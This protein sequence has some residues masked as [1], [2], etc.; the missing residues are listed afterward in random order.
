MDIQFEYLAD[1]PAPDRRAFMQA[2]REDAELRARYAEW[3]AVCEAVRSRQLQAIPARDLLVFAALE[4]AGM[5][6]LLSP[7]ERQRLRTEWPVLQDSLDAPSFLE[8]VVGRI[9]E[10][11]DDF[12]ASWA[13]RE[14]HL[15]SLDAGVPR[16]RPGRFVSV[17][18]RTS[19]VAAMIV[20]VGILLFVA[21]RDA[22]WVEI[23]IRQGEVRTVSMADGSSVR[24]MGPA[25][26]RYRSSGSADQRPQAFRLSGDAFFEVASSSV[27]LKVETPA[28]I[29]S[30]VGT[31][32]GVRSRSE[33]TD[34]VVASGRVSVAG[35][36]A[37]Q[38][39]II[40]SAGETCF[41]R[42]GEHPS[43]PETVDLADALAWADLLIFRGTTVAEI[44]VKL[45]D[46]FGV[47][48][49]AAPELQTKEITGTFDARRDVREI[50][51][52]LSL[53]LGAEVQRSADGF[54]LVPRQD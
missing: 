19:A 23:E 32:F 5:G 39:P 30:V 18:W 50:L 14:K 48:L 10:E 46:R 34:V 47:R 54:R 31:S 37:G 17:A 38:T 28:A 40:L 11:A 8:D 27:P 12:D 15:R 45:S 53:T 43:A 41:V 7:E 51:D 13:L 44:A 16:R 26:L 49:S 2:L 52:V 3:L 20:F 25:D 9:A 21:R 1:L 4:N 22:A 35:E 42:A 36:S 6:S 24:L 33:R 29:V